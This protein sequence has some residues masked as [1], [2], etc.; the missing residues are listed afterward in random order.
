MTSLRIWSCHLAA[1]LCLLCFGASSA[2]AAAHDLPFP[3]GESP[4]VMDGGALSWGKR[5]IVGRGRGGGRSEAQE[6]QGGCQVAAPD[7]QGGHQASHGG[8]RFPYG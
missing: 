6:T 1:A 2:P 8:A 5:Q 3:P 7:A 4:A